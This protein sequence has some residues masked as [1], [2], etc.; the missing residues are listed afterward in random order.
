M[1]G[2]GDSNDIKITVALDTKDAVDGVKKLTEEINLFLKRV[3]APFKKLGDLSKEVSKVQIAD[4]KAKRDVELQT[5]QDLDKA[6]QRKHERI[7]ERIRNEVAYEKI[8]SNEF[9]RLEKIRVDESNKLNAQKQQTT[10]KVIDDTTKFAIAQTAAQLEAEKSGNVKAAKDFAETEKTKR[11]EV[12][13]TIA[14]INQETAKIRKAPRTDGGDTAGSGKVIDGLKNSIAALSFQ[15]GNVNVGFGS[16][17]NNFKNLGAAGG[18]IAALAAAVGAIQKLDRAIDDLAAQANKVEGLAAGFN[19]L[20]R[21]VGQDPTKSIVAL[22]EATRGLISDVDLYQRANQAVLLGVPTKVFNEAAAAAVKLGRAMGIDA[23]FGLES[24]SLGLGRQSRLYLDNLGIIVSAEEAYKNFAAAIGKSANDLTDGEKKAAFFAEALSKIKQRAEELPEPLDTVGIALQ[25]LNAAQENAN[26]KFSE[27]FNSSKPL[28]EA[29]KEQAKIAEQNIAINERFGAATGAVGSIFKTLAN[30]IRLGT[31]VAKAGF[32]D[33]VGLFADLSKE[34]QLKTVE[35]NINSLTESTNRLREVRA[36]DG[37]GPTLSAR[38]KEE[39]AALAAAQKEAEALRLEIQKLRGEGAQGIKINV[40]TSDISTA[41]NDFKNFF[42][43]LRQQTSELGGNVQ[44]PGL[45]PETVKAVSDAYKELTAQQLQGKISTEQ[46]NAG[47]EKIQNTVGSELSAAK[48]KP[49]ADELASVEKASQTAGASSDEYA[50]KIATLRAQIKAAATDV[51][52]YGQAQEQLKKV[53]DQARSAGQKTFN[54]LTAGQKKSATEA[55]KILDKQEQQVEDFVK[56]VRR[57]T[58]NAVDPALERRLAELFKDAEVGSKEFEDGLRGIAQEAIKANGDLT[59][60]N[61]TLKAQQALLEQGIPKDKLPLNATDAEAAVAYNEELAKAQEG[62]INIRDAIFGNAE[63]Q[64]GGKKGGGAFFGFDLGETATPEAEAQAAGAFQDFLGSALQAGID[65]FSR[66]DVPALTAQLGGALGGAI[67]AAI[68]G[69]AGA[70]IGQQL[71][72][73]IGQIAGESLAEL[74]KDLEGTVERKQID[75]Y[76]NEIFAGDRLA[77]IIQGQVRRAVSNGVLIIGE[78]L[79]E[80]KP[81]IQRISDIVFEGFTPFAGMVR[82]GGEGFSTYF[83][84]LAADVQNTFT[85][86]GLALGT[87]QGVSAE[88]ARLIGTAISNN[89]G[90][91]LQNL[92]VL[93]QQTGE[94]FEDLSQAILKAFRDSQLTAGEAYNALVQLQNIYAEGIPGAIGDFKQAIENLNTSLESNQPGQYALDSLRDIGSEGQEAAASFDSVI[95]SLGQ[96]FNFTAQQQT[97]LFEALRLSG[98]TS[99]QQLAKASDEQLITLLRNIE[100]IKQ[101]AEAPLAAAPVLPSTAPSGAGR[102]RGK[103]PA[104]IAAD[105]LKKQR[106]EARKLTQESQ[107]YLKVIEKINAGQL[108]NVQAGKEI[109]QINAEILQLI[110]DRDATEKK[111]NAELDKGTKGNAKTIAELSAALQKLEERLGKVKEK[112]A[113]NKREYKDLNISAVIPLIKSQNTLG[114][115]A[116]QIGV[117]LKTNVDILVKGFLQGR[118]SIKQV[119]DEINKTKELLGPGIPNAVGAVTEAFQNLIDAGTQGGQFSADAFTDI[120]AEFREKF[121]KEGSAFQQAQRK[122]LNDNLDSARRALLTASGPEATEAARKALDL[123]KKAI[124][125][126]KNT[127][128]APDLSDLRD[129]LRNSFN[130]ADVEKFFQALDE[131]GLKSFEEL[132]G[133]SAEAIVGILGR[134]EELGF[135]FGET[136]DEAKGINKGLQD[137]ETAANAGLDPLKAA[138]DLV[139]SFNNAAGLL[140]PVFNSTTEAI[141]GMEQPLA[142]IGDKIAETIALLGRLGGQTFTNDIV[143]NIRTTGEQ[144]GKALVDLIFGD[145]SDASSDTGDGKKTPP[146]KETPTKETPSNTNGKRSDWIRQSP[147]IY[148]NR[149][150]GRIVKS[151]TNPGA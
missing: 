129:Q 130:P 139:K 117:D 16:F 93:V 15:F 82:F 119:N 19:T 137:A 121:V 68:G 97:R 20:Q 104:E 71:G 143:F 1:A 26:T 99:L 58:K 73:I 112:A 67:G 101:N 9:I 122:I 48:L 110:K 135:K 141:G 87:L 52:F 84:T 69:P 32:S 49:L 3:E 43:G 31:T 95:S 140:P 88:T 98:I 28:I 65:G 24:L 89:I 18:A 145:G 131:S 10:R 91:S 150:T 149:K 79:E 109:K 106:E 147:G 37:L 103:S 80:V 77:V 8:A 100:A 114:L 76:F 33:F 11:T 42:A 85:G 7:L 61:K 115:V 55:Q 123:A 51:G 90:G 126:F 57:T 113:E 21:T 94:S 132:E 108:S 34:D 45:K 13:K 144:G 60:L 63:V 118:M 72:T 125:D 14:L 44:V 25:K 4:I 46:L 23:A 30:D 35:A 54:D 50:E 2:F 83:N 92:Q 107:E 36:K 151:K 64:D 127:P 102:S 22:R 56:S 124:E 78:T 128:V 40:D 62:I 47:L 59:A 133:A 66:E 17:I 53:L 41:Q 138:I 116:R 111:L 12:L 86:V 142:K 27:G 39:E 105:L 74:G 70:Q 96:T 75:K 146:K 6:N 38:L 120:F 5:L 29:Y 136:S 81:Q 134:L 148:K